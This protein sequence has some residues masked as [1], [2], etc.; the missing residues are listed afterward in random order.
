MTII[1]RRLIAAA[2]LLAVIGAGMGISQAQDAPA[3]L[4]RVGGHADLSGAWQ[5]PYVP[6]MTK[7]GRGQKGKPSLPFTPLGL[8]EW[9]A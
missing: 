6:D 7:D 1:R 4:R 9:Q 2:A 3:P 5:A 8:K